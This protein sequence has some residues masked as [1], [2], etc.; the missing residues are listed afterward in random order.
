MGM[1]EVLP[2]FRRRGLA[3]V[4]EAA[5]IAQQLERGRFPYCHVRHGNAAS[6]ALQKKLGLT[7]KEYLYSIRLTHACRLLTHTEKSIL[8]ISLEAGFPD[9]RAFSQQFG[10]IYHTTPKEYRRQFRHT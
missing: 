3:E 6:E 7:F 9:M 4:L 5:L 1:L 10:R 8:D 2:Q